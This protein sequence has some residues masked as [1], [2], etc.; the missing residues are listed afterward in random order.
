LTAVCAFLLLSLMDGTASGAVPI[1]GAN[2][3]ALAGEPAREKEG[4][5]ILARYLQASKNRVVR[6]ISMVA[7]FAGS[8]PKMKMRGVADARR[9]VTENGAI[10]YEVSARNGDNT[11]WKEL[12]LR[13][14]NGEMETATKDRSKVAINPE[15]YR[16]KYKGQRERDGRMAHVFEVNPRKKREGLFKGELWVDVE[17]SLPV[18]ESGKLV[19]SPSVFLKNVQFTREYSL[20]DGIPVPKAMQ[21]SIQTRFWGLAELDVQYSEFEWERSQPASE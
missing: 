8:L 14:M 6:G 17:T 5:Q 18:L 15:N 10:E 16:F 11:V 4:D 9:R 7:H 20:Q 12:I 1:P 2:V 21:T 19:K 13:F 3:V